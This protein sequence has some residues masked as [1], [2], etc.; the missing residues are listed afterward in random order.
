MGAG[1]PVASWPTGRLLS[2]AARLVEHS[3]QEFLATR[4][5]THAGLIALHLLREGPRTQ[6][7]LAH[8]A[9]VTDQTMSRTVERL[10]RAGFVERGVDPVDRRRMVV[11]LTDE[12][13]EVHA[14]ALRAERE[15]PE[16]LGAV[17]DY[18]AFRRQLVELVTVLGV[19]RTTSARPDPRG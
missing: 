4:G 11:S 7:A 16:V 15:E 2:V 3:W 14:E 12:G 18:E 9:K 5:L 19:D 13:R 6:R 17:R 8:G 10:H 1:D